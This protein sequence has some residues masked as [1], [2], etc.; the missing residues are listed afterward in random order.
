MR[1]SDWPVNTAAH[2]RDLIFLSFKFFL[3]SIAP[4]GSL[5]MCHFFKNVPRETYVLTKS[6]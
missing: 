4:S 1:A 5:E 2:S 3:Q 6:H